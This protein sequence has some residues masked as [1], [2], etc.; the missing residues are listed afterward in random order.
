MLHNSS[1]ILNLGLRTIAK[2]LGSQPILNMSVQ[3]F[4]WG[5]DDPLIKFAH[6]LIPRK[7]NFPKLGILDRVSKVE[8]TL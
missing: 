2:Y 6:T 5:Y 3:D 4:M 8:R 7:I 1:I